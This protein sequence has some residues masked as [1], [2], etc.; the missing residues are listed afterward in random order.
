MRADRRRAVNGCAQAS[1]AAWTLASFF[2]LLWVARPHCAS[3]SRTACADTWRAKAALRWPG[4]TPSA[5]QPTAK[6]QSEPMRPRSRRLTL[7]PLSGIG[8]EWLLTAPLRGPAMPKSHSSASDP[9]PKRPQASDCATTA[10]PADWS[11]RAFELPIRRRRLHS[12]FT[13]KTRRPVTSDRRRSRTS[14][15]PVAATRPRPGSAP[16]FRHAV[17]S[18]R[19]CNPKAA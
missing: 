2:S 8:E 11:K 19:R 14:A 10:S 1:N 6:P 17:G 5:A 15:L 18:S 13:L 3:C 12:G 7:G 4:D 9:R 16:S